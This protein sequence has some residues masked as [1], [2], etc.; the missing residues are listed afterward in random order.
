MEF[1]GLPLV[2]V[3]IRNSLGTAYEAIFDFETS[4]AQSERTY[5]LYAEELGRE[6]P[7]T[8]AT[9]LD[10]GRLH[11]KMGAFKEA[12]ELWGD[13]A[14]R[15]RETQGPEFIL[16]RLATSYYAGS[17]INL[18][19]VEEGHEI[20]RRE[21]EDLQRVLG[22]NSPEVL[23]CKNSL[24]SGLSRTGQHAEAVP[25]FQECLENLISTKGPADPETLGMRENL[26]GCLS[27]MG[28]PEEAL[29]EYRVLLVDYEGLF[30]ADHPKVAMCRFH[31]GSVLSELERHQ[32]A[33]D[34]ISTALAIHQSLYGKHHPGTL[35]CG[36]IQFA[37][38]LDLGEFEAAAKLGEPLFEDHLQAPRYG[39]DASATNA[40][41]GR[42]GASFAKWNEQDPSSERAAKAQKYTA[43]HEAWK[44][45][46]D[47]EEGD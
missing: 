3:E 26:I 7:N 22:P 19:R 13:A 5:A 18:D 39:Q 44:R 43:M 23:Q 25:L 33:F 4:L 1:E 29:A 28:S 36:R 38:M 24:A 35:A 21:I 37:A 17:L 16:T 11:A 46:Y 45:K 34:E 6:D 15:L 41:A 30:P 27:D 8:L 9:Q 47:P 40:V 2:E 31:I 32:E 14:D 12:A 42:L 10:L 20:L